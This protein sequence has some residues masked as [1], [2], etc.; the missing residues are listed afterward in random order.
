LNSN[1]TSSYCIVKK[2]G[3]PGQNRNT[4]ESVTCAEWSDLPDKD[5]L[6]VVQVSIG[7]NEIIRR[8]P[9][10]EAERIAIAYR[11]LKELMA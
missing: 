2:G 5:S 3:V 7:T 11:K 4:I 1:I 9:A 6:E 8:Y 10:I